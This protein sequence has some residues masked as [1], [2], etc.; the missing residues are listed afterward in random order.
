[1]F[2]QISIRFQRRRI[3]FSQHSPVN[4]ENSVPIGTFGLQLS[5]IVPESPELDSMIRSQPVAGQAQSPAEPHA[6]QSPTQLS[7]DVQFGQRDPAN[8]NNGADPENDNDSDNEPQME[9]PSG[10]PSPSRPMGTEANVSYFETMFKGLKQLQDSSDALKTENKKLKAKLA[11]LEEE[12]KTAEAKHAKEISSLKKKHEEAGTK[13]AEDKRNIEDLLA[14]AKAS[15]S[16]TKLNLQKNS[17]LAE[18]RLREV[19]ELQG[20]LDEAHTREAVTK[21]ELARLKSDNEEVTKAY[22]RLQIEFEGLRNEMDVLRTENSRLEGVVAGKVK[23][24]ARIEKLLKGMSHLLTEF[25]SGRDTQSQEL[26]PQPPQNGGGFNM[27]PDSMEDSPKS[28][29]PPIVAA[30]EPIAS[31]G[32]GRITSPAEPGMYVPSTVIK[33]RSPRK[34]ALTLKETGQPRARRRTRGQNARVLV[35]DSDSGE[36][37]E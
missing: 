4:D 7:Q 33:P 11:K 29:E 8:E 23:E 18:Q 2:A 37:D 5:K 12:S 21:T 34:G 9:L 19:E 22:E 15:V 24:E 28:Q 30:P 1:M 26:A 16:A 3:S 17:E 13:F 6:T 32:G 25:H 31:S 14:K 35:N 36:G 27:F 10:A 20:K